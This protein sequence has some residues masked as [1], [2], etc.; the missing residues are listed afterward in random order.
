MT[1]RTFLSGAVAALLLLATG[2]AMF[3][4]EKGRKTATAEIRDAKGQ[5]V[6]EAKFKETAGGVQMSVKVMNLP[7]GDRAIHIHQAGKCDAPDFKTAGPHFNPAHKKHG[8]NNPEGHHAG[9][10]RERGRARGGN[11]ARRP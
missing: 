3:G 7:P 4:A 2:G 5:K 9:A 1:T 11:G 6:G 8:V 10:A